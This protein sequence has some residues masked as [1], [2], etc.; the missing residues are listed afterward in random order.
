VDD[1]KLERLAT[2]L[3]RIGAASEAVP[4]EALGELGALA[5]EDRLTV[6]Y[7]AREVLGHPL[8]VWQPAG[9]LPGWWSALTP[10]EK[11]VA[12]LVADGLSNAAVA[13]RLDLGVGTVKDHV[14]AVL[15]KAKL[16]RRSQIAA[17]LAA[18]G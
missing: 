11:E 17:A 15:S 1:A 2:V 3:A 8:V 4:T 12:A 10:R 9:E 7:R 16:R 13:R 14:H 5:G 18:R 6:D